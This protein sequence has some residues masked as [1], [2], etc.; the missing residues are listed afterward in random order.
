ML[1][2]I[3]I[4]LF[5]VHFV[6]GHFENP[7][8]GSRILY[9]VPGRG[10]RVLRE[11]LLHKTTSA[12][13][14]G[15]QSSPKDPSFLSKEGGRGRP[16][17]PS[18]LPMHPLRGQILGEGREPR[19]LWAHRG[20]SVSEAVGFCSVSGKLGALGSQK[21]SVQSWMDKSLPTPCRGAGRHRQRTALLLPHSQRDGCWGEWGVGWGSSQWQGRL[22]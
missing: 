22:E 20:I 15:V 5:L 9:A 19:L 12:S 21:D 2:F 3:T 10:R 16:W 14:A 4:T 11:L 18:R 13:P 6:W 7:L 1:L 8:T 17:C